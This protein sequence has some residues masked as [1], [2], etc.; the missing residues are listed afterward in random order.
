MY[1][2]RREEAELAVTCSASLPNVDRF[3]GEAA[4]L[5][6]SHG[7]AAEVFAVELLLR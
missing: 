1:Q 4:D 3:C 5:L 6:R 7:L 2:E